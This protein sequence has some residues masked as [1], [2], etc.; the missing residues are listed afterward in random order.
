ML[1]NFKVIE[2]KKIV[3]ILIILG[4][5]GFFSVPH[6]EAAALTTLSD[7]LSRLQVSLDSNHNIT[8][9]SPS[10]VSAGE[11]IEI[12]FPSNFS[13]T[14]VDYTD[15]DLSD[16][17]ADI[18]LAAVAAGTTWGASFGGTGNRTLTII[19]DTGTI[20]A[21]SIINIKI[22]TNA[23]FGVNGD[24]VINN[25]S[26]NNNYIL[27]IAGTFGDTGDIP[28]II[29]ADD[30][31]QITGDIY[32]SLDFAISDNSI[33]FGNMSNTNVKYATADGLGAFSEPGNDLP[34]KLTAGTNAV[35]GL[36]I[37]ISDKGDDVSAGLYAA[38]VTELVPAAPSTQVINN[39]KKYGAYG[40]HSVGLTIDPG[41]DNNSVADVA[42]SR[43]AQ[44]FASSNTLVNGS[45]D[46]ALLVAVD[47]TTHPGAYS[48]TLTL[49]CTGNY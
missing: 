25:P 47:S 35:N 48:D 38:L 8:F 26:T 41:F 13:T 19:S 20:V 7:T 44:T 31:I 5:T 32:P 36:T 21:A 1:K 43:T 40:K 2:I 37:A 14:S 22:G 6:S 10:G 27:S 17:G 24:Q 34:V 39:S 9:T 49:T 15:I 23:T 12:T 11:S 46:L 42:I 28:L 33:G 45:V 4:L 29:I 16:D 18:A 3:S 30:Q